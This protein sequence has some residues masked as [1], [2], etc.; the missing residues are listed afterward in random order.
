MALEISNS[1]HAMCAV[2]AGAVPAYV[3]NRGFAAAITRNGA[4]DYSLTLDQGID[5]TQSSIHVTPRESPGAIVT[6]VH[7]SDT[8]KQILL[9]DAAGMATDIDFDVLVLAVPSQ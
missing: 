1:F 7:T 2:D 4:G 3:F 5:S 9:F 8:S 6:A